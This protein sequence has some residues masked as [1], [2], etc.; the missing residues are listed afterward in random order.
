M[1]MN[2]DRY[3]NGR[4][5]TC[6]PEWHDEDAAWK[7]SQILDFI[8]TMLPLPS[9]ICDI[10]CGTGGVL[11][12]LVDQ[13]PGTRLFGVEPSPQAAKLAQEKHPRIEIINSGVSA[14]DRRVELVMA[15]DV[16]EH[17]EDYFTFLRSLHG[18]APR[19]LFHIPLEMSVSAVARM[20]PLIE[21]RTRIGHLHYFS[22]E[23]ALAVLAECGYT[24][25]AERYTPAA[26]SAPATRLRTSLLR[27]PRRTGSKVVPHLTA[28]LLGGFSLLI[29]AELAPIA[30]E[31]T[32]N[33]WWRLV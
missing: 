22:R 20:A 1:P 30:H 27:L 15:L 5:E 28:R 3:R 2:Q 11:D 8:S 17:V 32:G 6:N 4:Y 23:T 13:L 26:L 31:M 7:A 21:G 16:F 24:V 9:S 14:I 33:R 29:M 19:Y 25:I 10:G 12:A 18:I